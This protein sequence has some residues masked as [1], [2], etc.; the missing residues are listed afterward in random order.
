L[1][2]VNSPKNPTH[3]HISPFPLPPHYR[4]HHSSRPSLS[5]V[6]LIQPRVT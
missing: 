6:Q 4:H 3:I 5:V 1:I 2:H